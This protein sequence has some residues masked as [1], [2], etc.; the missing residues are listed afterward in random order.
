MRVERIIK[1]CLDNDK[2]AWDIFVQKYSKLIYW[3]IRRRLRVHNFYFGQDDVD[4]IFQEVFLSILSGNK[5]A[6]IRDIKM[7][8]GWLAVT[9]SNQAVD[10]MRRKIKE[11][12]RFISE[13]PDFGDDRLKEELV[14]RDLSRLIERIING[15]SSK[16]KIVISL[17]LIE[18]RTHRDIAGIVG[19]PVN[20]ISTIIFRVKQKL[21]KELTKRGLKYL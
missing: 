18:G 19:M 7:I 20:S 3:S 10:F 2:K 9:A 4:C 6:Q 21:K 11:N 16:E 12:D 14:Q 1:G 17:N 13:V 8:S 15:L 5:L